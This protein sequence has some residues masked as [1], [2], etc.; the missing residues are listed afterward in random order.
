MVLFL[1]FSIFYPQPKIQIILNDGTTK[2][3]IDKFNVADLDLID[4]RRIVKGAIQGVDIQ[5]N[6]VYFCPT[7][8]YFWCIQFGQYCFCFTVKHPIQCDIFHFCQFRDK[9]L[10]KF[11]TGQLC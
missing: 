6:I 8:N 4:Q 2:Y 5:G 7:V 11:G 3:R 1:L 9:V 10:D